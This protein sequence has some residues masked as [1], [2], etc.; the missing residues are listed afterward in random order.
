MFTLLATPAANLV[1]E[2]SLC[3]FEAFLLLGFQ[4]ETALVHGL[5]RARTCAS[6]WTR[7]CFAICTALGHSIPVPLYTSEAALQSIPEF[8]LLV[9]VQHPVQHL[10]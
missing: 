6:L 3:V 8:R 1:V 9:F 2:C 7:A 4:S 5:C 10:H